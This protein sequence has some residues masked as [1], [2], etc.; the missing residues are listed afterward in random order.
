MKKINRMIIHGFVFELADKTKKFECKGEII[1]EY[2]RIIPYQNSDGELA[3]QVNIAI[4]EMAEKHKCKIC[5]FE[6]NSTYTNSLCLED[7]LFYD[8]YTNNENGQLEQYHIFVYEDDDDN[9]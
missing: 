4:E 1:P 7:V 6:S 5:I 3:I 9:K 2:C 8:L